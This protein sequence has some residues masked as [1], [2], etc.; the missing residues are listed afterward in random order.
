[1]LCCE[2]CG[3]ATECVQK[4]VDGDE[5]NVCDQCWCPPAVVPGGK[6]E[7]KTPS[8]TPDEEEIEETL[9]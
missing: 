5:L 2:L 9:I 8:E 4:Q 1:M 3:E 7:A 6:V